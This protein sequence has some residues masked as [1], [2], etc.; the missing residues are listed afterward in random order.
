MAVVIAAAVASIVGV[1]TLTSVLVSH[2]QP[3]PTAA[4]CAAAASGVGSRLTI[5]G[6]GYA[7]N[8]TYLVDI[9]W[10]AGNMSSQSALTDGSGGLYAWNYAYY[11]GSYS[12]AVFTIGSHPTQVASCSTTVS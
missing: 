8:T 1:S 12:V 6:S 7:T 10:P 11:T 5:T 2:K 9:T 3:V 4:T